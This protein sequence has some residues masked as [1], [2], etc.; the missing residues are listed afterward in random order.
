MDK[1][2]YSKGLFTVLGITNEILPFYGYADQCRQL[3]TQLRSKSRKLWEDNIDNWFK[4][5]S[6]VKRTINIKIDSANKKKLN[7]LKENK[8]Y[9]MFKIVLSL[10]KLRDI[11]IF[12]DFCDK[13]DKIELLEISKVYLPN[14]FTKCDIKI[15]IQT[16]FDKIKKESP[17]AIE[18]D[19]VMNKIINLPEL[20]YIHN[21]FGTDREGRMV[22]DT[23]VSEMPSGWEEKKRHSEILKS[24]INP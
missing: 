23:R 7:L 5:L 17:G 12:F 20:F 13:I 21:G 24:L 18:E 1:S 3:M 16:F 19:W 15:Y 8:R 9:A 11:S 4:T 22:V 14:K 2:K 6:C 10:D